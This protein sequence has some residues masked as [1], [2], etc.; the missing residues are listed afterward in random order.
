VVTLTPHEFVHSTN[1]LV[2]DYVD[3]F[4]TDI[5]PRKEEAR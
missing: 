3:A 5:S 4:K 2:A 1:P